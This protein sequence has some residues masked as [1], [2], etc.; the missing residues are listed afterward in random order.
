MSASFQAICRPLGFSS[1]ENNRATEYLWHMLA[2]ANSAWVC[3]LCWCSGNYTVKH[4]RVFIFIW[5]NCA[6]SSNNTDVETTEHFI[7]L[8]TRYVCDFSGLTNFSQK[9]W[10]SKKTFIS[11]F[12]YYFGFLFFD[13]RWILWYLWRN[14]VSPTVCLFE[15]LV[16]GQFIRKSCFLDRLFACWILRKLRASSFARSIKFLSLLSEWVDDWSSSTWDNSPG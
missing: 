3:W 8:H 7:L 2:P 15:R 14:E 13:P 9:L 16:I 1:T 12:V 10:N 6:V 4:K 5:L 11:Y